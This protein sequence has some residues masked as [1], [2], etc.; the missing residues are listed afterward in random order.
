MKNLLK[1][2]L[3]F[4]LILTISACAPSREEAD[5]KLLKACK[6]AVEAV[7]PN[8]EVIHKIL[9]QKFE[10]KKSHDGLDLRVVTIEGKV[11]IGNS[12]YRRKTY[13]C[14]FEEKKGVFGIGYS[15]D[16]WLLDRNGRMYGNVDGTIVGDF[17]DNL[18][19]N[20][21]VSKILY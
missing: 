18:K 7:S 4:T 19:I 6:A 2:C 10:N 20:E 17:N 11:T 16:F 5:K 12:A 8:K 3:V 1:I 21:A 14:S 9:S 13:R 15:A